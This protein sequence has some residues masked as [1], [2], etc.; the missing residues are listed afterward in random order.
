MIQLYKLATGN[1]KGR[2]ATSTLLIGKNATA[3]L[4]DY[5]YVT[6]TGSYWYWNSALGI[7]AWVNQ[8]IAEASFAA[9]SNA[10]KAALPY[11]V[12]V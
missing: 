5:A 10:E 3:A 11:I 12:G 4:S 2:Y 6:D 8:Q 9:L 7:P 1:Y